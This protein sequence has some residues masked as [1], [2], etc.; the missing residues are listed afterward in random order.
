MSTSHNKI[1][2]FSKEDYDDWKI[3]MQD[4][5]A[6]QDDDMWS[7]IID[8]PMKIIK[9]NI[10]F[11]TSDGAPKY[12]EKRR[13]EYTNEEKKKANLDNVARDILYKTLDKNM[14]SKIKTCA[15]IYKYGNEET[16]QIVRNKNTK[17]YS[18]NTSPLPSS[19][20]VAARRRCRRHRPP[21]PPPS[22]FVPTISER[23]LRP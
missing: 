7:V 18:A 4:H 11:A 2:M 21:P 3:R 14:F 8:G 10:A 1:P 16:L 23:R 15:I 6:A 13:H 19:L 9:I 5:L 17:S 22:E 20:A 12:V